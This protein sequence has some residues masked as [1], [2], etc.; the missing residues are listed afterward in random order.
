MFLEC[1]WCFGV[2]EGVLGVF[3]LVLKCLSWF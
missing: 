3:E 1:V 2:F